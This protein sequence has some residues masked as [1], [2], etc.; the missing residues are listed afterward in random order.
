M[1]DEKDNDQDSMFKGSA[2]NSNLM[3]DTAQNEQSAAMMAAI[4]A[5]KR[6]AH[7]S[8]KGSNNNNMSP[9]IS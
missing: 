8:C 7:P 4:A 2:K 9:D 3:Q 1:E 6:Q 5:T